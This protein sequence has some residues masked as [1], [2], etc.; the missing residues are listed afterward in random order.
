[1]L[2]VSYNDA[3]F[4]GQD[5]DKKQAHTELIEAPCGER[6][7][8]QAL[9]EFLLRTSAAMYARDT[10][11]FAAAQQLYRDAI[12]VDKKPIP[13]QPVLDKPEYA[14]VKARIRLLLQKSEQKLNNY[15]KALDLEYQTVSELNSGFGGPFASMYWSR[16]SNDGDEFIIVAVKGVCHLIH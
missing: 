6:V 11:V 2:I 7:Y 12:A 15:A 16:N 10:L 1:M 4:E 5:V 8:S 13:S 3:E 9:A 14:S